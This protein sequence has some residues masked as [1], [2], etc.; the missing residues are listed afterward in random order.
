MQFVKVDKTS[1][2]TSP[3]LRNGKTLLLLDPTTS[4]PNSGI[5]THTLNSEALVITNEE[6]Y[7]LGRSFAGNVTI[8]KLECGELFT[9]TIHNYEIR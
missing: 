9:N 4:L 3:R 2:P 8:R 1:L 5:T 6:V 7:M